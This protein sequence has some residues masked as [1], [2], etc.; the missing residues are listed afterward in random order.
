MTTISGNNYTYLGTDL[1]NALGFLITRI[2][3]ATSTDTLP[4]AANLILAY[5][6]S[7]DAANN[8]Q[9]FGVSIFNNSSFTIT[10]NTGTGITFTGISSDTILPQATRTYTFV[11]TAVSTISCYIVGGAPNA[12]STNTGITLANNNILV[13]N[14][15]SIATGVAMSGDASIA[16]SGALTLATVNGTAGSFNAANLTVNAK[17]L[18]TTVA[19]GVAGSNTELQFNNTGALGSSSNLTW[20]GSTLSATQLTSTV[21]TG[22]APLVVTST[23]QVANLNAATSGTSTNATLAND[24][25]SANNFLVFSN[26][27][28]GSQPLKTTSNCR[29][30]PDLTTGGIFILN[31]PAATSSTTGAMINS[32]GEG[33]AKNIWIGSNFTA[34]NTT[35]AGSVINVPSFTYTSSTSNPTNVNIDTLNQITLNGTGTATNASSLYIAGPPIAGTLAITNPYSLQVASGNSIF[36]GNVNVTGNLSAVNHIQGYTTTA[37]AAGTT[38]LTVS[39][40]FQQYFTGTTTQI[41]TMPVTSTLVL[42]QS[43]YIVNNSTNIVTINSSGANL[44]TALAGN[45]SAILTCILTSGTTATSWSVQRVDL[46]P[47]VTYITTGTTYTTPVFITTETQFII[48]LVGG[49]GG[50]GGVSAAGTTNHSGGGGA[51]AVGIISISGLTPNT[52]YTIVLGAAGIAGTG[53]GGGGTGGTG[54][55]TSIVINGTTYQALGGTGGAPASGGIGGSVGTGTFVLSIKGQNGGDGSAVNSTSAPAGM[56]G[57]TG[58]GY[59]LG[60]PS[61]ITASGAN[62]VATGYGGG[63]G[64]GSTASNAGGAGTGGLIVIEYV[65]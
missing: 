55:T 14:A 16:S 18:I 35:T 40:N 20:N 38:T 11:Q 45:T 22:T 19:S 2:P 13:G 53:G 61:F 25:A 58:L 27:A 4:T 31:S 65:A 62:N 17:G 33:I 57:N 9:S 32:G 37:T 59:G 7:N 50:G 1:A 42:G 36:G 44:I 39:S 34:A 41:V 52:A 10:L 60:G 15:S 54:G 24:V 30:N 6:G 23:T 46:Q 26:V 56:G 47:R 63:G 29:Y 5:V 51:G 21:T 28:T 8:G 43:F 49:G 64:G 48:T 3:T 12:P